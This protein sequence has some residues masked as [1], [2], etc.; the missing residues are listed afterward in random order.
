MERNLKPYYVIVNLKEL[1]YI[2]EEF[3]GVELKDAKRFDERIDAENFLLNKS[4]GVRGKCAIYLVKTTV[5]LE[6]V[7][8][9]SQVGA[10]SFGTEGVK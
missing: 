6:Q 9:G 7:M 1:C 2:D 8:L 3:N 10:S 4:I 5:S